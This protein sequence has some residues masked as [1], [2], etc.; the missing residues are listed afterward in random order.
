MTTFVYSRDF[1]RVSRTPEIQPTLPPHY[2]R[3][4]PD[5]DELAPVMTEAWAE[6]KEYF[7]S[8]A[9][10]SRFYD[11]VHASIGKLGRAD[12]SNRRPMSFKWSHNDSHG[13]HGRKGM[14]WRQLPGAQHR[15]L[16]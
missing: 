3:V 9:F 7:V 15:V 8:N 1:K 16:H 6:S 4:A 12:P 14:K 10:D 11:L 2:D 5:A 13:P